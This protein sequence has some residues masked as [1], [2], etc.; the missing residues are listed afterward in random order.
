MDN[1]IMQNN[2]PSPLNKKTLWLHFKTC[3]GKEYQKPRYWGKEE[4][5]NPEKNMYV[6]RRAQVYE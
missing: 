5:V 3:K 6:N 2:F 1:L 4:G